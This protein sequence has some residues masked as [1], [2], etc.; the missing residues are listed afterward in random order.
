MATSVRKGKKKKNQTTSW[1]HFQVWFQVCYR[2]R[3]NS[4]SHQIVLILASLLK[5]VET[6]QGD[7]K[8]KKKSKPNRKQEDIHIGWDFEKKKSSE[9]SSIL[10]L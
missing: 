4:Q 6:V 9:K 10:Q 5:F 2:Q 3:S 8:K 1:L 7:F